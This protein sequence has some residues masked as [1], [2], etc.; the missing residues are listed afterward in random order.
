MI[1]SYNYGKTITILVGPEEHCFVAHQDAICA[2][3]EFFR[4]ACSKNWREGQEK[5]LR[6]PET[7]SEQAFQTYMHW[8][9][10]NQLVLKQVTPNTTLEPPTLVS[11]LNAALE[12]YDELIE[13]YLLGDFLNDV[14]LRNEVIKSLNRHAI[15]AMCFLEAV[16]LHSIWNNT[17]SDSLLRTWVVDAFISLNSSDILDFFGKDYPADFLLRVASQAMERITDHG[18]DEEGLEMRLTA[19]LEHDAND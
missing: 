12:V 14:K 9:Y 15:G 13:L 18:A 3:S 2:K 5:V 19:Y 16:Q 4:A 11:K 7:R 8:T 10:T 6:L 17:P 1:A